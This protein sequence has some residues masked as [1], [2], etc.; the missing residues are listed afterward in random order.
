MSRGA[1]N[2]L[3]FALATPLL[4]MVMA[5]V[6]ERSESDS[7]SLNRVRDEVVGFL[8]FRVFPVVFFGVCE[9]GVKLCDFI[10]IALVFLFEIK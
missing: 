7:V 10:L 6:W 4:P 2:K 8:S 9:S 5:M 1:I 3:L